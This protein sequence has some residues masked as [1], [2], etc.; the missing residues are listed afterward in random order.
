MQG[1]VQ[2]IALHLD[3]RQFTLDLRKLHL[4]FRQRFLVPADILQ[5]AG[6]G[7]SYPVC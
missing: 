1:Q 3:L 2:E 7:R 4:H 5:L 6:L